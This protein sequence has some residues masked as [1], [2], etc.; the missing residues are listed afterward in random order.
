MEE[1]ELA[2]TD[3]PGAL[4]LNQDEIGDMFGES[5]LDNA[6]S[7]SFGTVKI[8]KESAQF[9]LGEQNF[10]NTL[11]GHVLFKH[12]ANQYFEAAY[13]PANTSPPDCYSVDGYKPSG[14][15]NMKDCKCCAVCDLN[16]FG[17]GKEGR[18]K[19]CRNTVRFLFLQEGSVLPVIVIAPPTSLGKKG[20]VQ[21]WFNS[22][23]N[24][25]AR[26]YNAVGM[27]G[28]GKDG[29]PIVEYWTAKVE[30]S[31]KVET[32][33][34]GSSS[35]LKIK[36]LEVIV[37]KNED[38]S[39]EPVG[40]AKLRL[41]HSA[42]TKSRKAYEEERHAYIESEAGDEPVAAQG[43]EAESFNDTEPFNPDEVIPE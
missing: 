12:D 5:E 28:M 3:Q 41:L 36:T 4:A 33:A 19:A 2:K 30:L 16:A 22:V 40:G 26:A 43:N 39:Q 11:V 38:G 37:P 9:E 34:G 24:D 6:T 7:L 8:M 18:S 20:S 31:L 15:E 29:G 1:K 32:F 27:E 42:V 21:E 25:V 13:D 35:V 10:I 14:G 23:P 17:S